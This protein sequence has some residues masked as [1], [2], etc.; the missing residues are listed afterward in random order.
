VTFDQKVAQLNGRT[1]SF[2]PGKHT[3]RSCFLSLAYFVLILN[4]TSCS[5][6]SPKLNPTKIKQSVNQNG[7]YPKKTRNPYLKTSHLQNRSNLNSPEFSGSSKQLAEVMNIAPLLAQMSSLKKAGKTQSFSWLD[8]RQTVLERT[9]LTQNEVATTIANLDCDKE[10]TEILANQLQESQDDRTK[11]L[12]LMAII[13]G[14]AGAAATGGLSL[15]GLDTASN[16]LAIA[17]GGI[18]GGIGLFALSKEQDHLFFHPDNPLREAWLNPE[19]SEL[20][21]PAV[22]K[23]LNEPSDPKSN[24]TR[25]EKLIEDWKKSGWL[26]DSP[27]DQNHRLDLFFG[28]GGQYTLDELQD[29]AQIIDVLKDEASLTY[30]RIGKFLEEFSVFCLSS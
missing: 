30:R 27:E 23:F 2:M 5:T 26:G 20:L 24:L 4:I 7:C 14:A 10:Q 29:R 22:W 1:G 19:Q 13:V 18:S 3:S 6:A 21:P 15:A 12:A 8:L 17:V 28:N 25:R 11:T 16:V 9:V